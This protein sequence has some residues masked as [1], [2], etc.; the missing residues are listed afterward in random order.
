VLA[1]VAAAA[2]VGVFLQGPIPQDPAF[3]D[4][5]DQRV[6]FGVPH[7]WNVATNLPFA[8]WDASPTGDLIPVPECQNNQ[9]LLFSHLPV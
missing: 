7:F 6:L 1:A 4:F 9:K 3:H 2:V 5:A 8:T